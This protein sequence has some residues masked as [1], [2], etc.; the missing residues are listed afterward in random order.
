MNITL[1]VH[2]YTKYW[3]ELLDNINWF[4]TI[5]IAPELLANKL[6]L[7]MAKTVYEKYLVAVPYITSND[8][9]D[10][11]DDDSPT[12]N[13]KKNLYFIALYIKP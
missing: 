2:L 4:W 7:N 11:A 8:D 3:E 12:T 13:Y 1:K 9:D 5:F 6:K 10:D